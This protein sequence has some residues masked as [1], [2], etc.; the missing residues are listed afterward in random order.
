MSKFLKID[1]MKTLNNSAKKTEPERPRLCIQ[2]GESST[3]VFI[4]VVGNGSGKDT[5]LHVC[6]ADVGATNHCLIWTD[7]QQTR[8]HQT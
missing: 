7:N 3:L 4:V 8:V 1:E 6:A 5:K 2:K